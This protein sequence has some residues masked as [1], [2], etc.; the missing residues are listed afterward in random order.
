[1]SDNLHIDETRDHSGIHNESQRCDF[2][3]P[4]EKIELR[5][6]RY[7]EERGRIEGFDL[8]DWLR[9]EREVLAEEGIH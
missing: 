7:Y 2:P 5:A 6:Y 9:A 4:S 1:M 8:D 3:T